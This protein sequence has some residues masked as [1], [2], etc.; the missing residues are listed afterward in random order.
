MKK[1]RWSEILK[2]FISVI[3]CELAGVTGSIFTSP[4]IPHWYATL[5]KPSFSPPNSIFAPVWTSLYFLMGISAYLVWRKGLDNHLVNSAL[6]LFIIQL[7]LNTFWSILF[8]GLRSPVLGL[9]EIIILWIA[10]LLTT[11]SFFRVSKIAGFLLLPYIL[12]VS[13][14]VILNFSIWRLNL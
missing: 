4:A 12:W 1:I 7:I 13:F 5:V 2:F 9:I 11:F 8:F 14:A 6:R 3:I 10:I